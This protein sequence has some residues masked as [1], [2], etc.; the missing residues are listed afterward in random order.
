MS[1]FHI[2][3]ASQQ[4]AEHLRKE[5]AAGL[6]S[7]EMCGSDRLAEELGIGRGTAELALRQ[8]EREGWLVG[9][10]PR[11]RRHIV[12]PEGHVPRALR[13]AIF[14]QSA[15][16]RKDRMVNELEAHLKE[17]GHAVSYSEKS[18]LDLG[19]DPRR[20]ARQVARSDAQAW[21]LVAASREVLEWFAAQP[22]PSFA[23][24][25]ARFGLPIASVG[26]DKEKA[27]VDATRE[28]LRQG[29]TR[30]S[31]ICRRLHRTPVPSQTVRVIRQELNNAGVRTGSFNAPD[32]EESP[33][34]LCEC[35]DKLFSLTPPTA[36]IVDEIP[37]FVAVQQYLARRGIRVP[38]DVSLVSLDNDEILS[39]CGL[40]I[41]HISWNLRPLIRHA[42]R[43]ADSVSR[44]KP[45]R[46]QATS[47]ATFVPGGSIGPSP[48]RL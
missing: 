45:D 8:L 34:G 41:A 48:R 33:A 18:L 4:V 12:A 47:F 14:T 37:F 42:V 15:S 3:S 28:L 11:C 6:R 40:S 5:M 1:P 43:W 7:G 38:D 44:G 16:D 23:F 20:V 19:M 21:I 32:W 17:A 31:V 30:I 9:H 29:H 13:L 27:L 35:L 36:L 2:L 24:F 26:P 25:G 39:F 10:G 22:V 46:R